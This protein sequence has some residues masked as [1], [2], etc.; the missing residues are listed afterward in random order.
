MGNCTSTK[1]NS[2]PVSYSH[3]LPH[4]P[5]YEETQTCQV[6]I[7]PDIKDNN[8]YVRNGNYD[9]LIKCV[10]LGPPKT[11]K[12]LL[13]S[14]LQDGDID[15]CSNKYRTTIGADFSIV[16]AKYKS[17]NV[18]LQ[19]W[20]SMGDKRFQSITV[21]YLRGAKIVFLFCDLNHPKDMIKWLN[22][23]HK[24]VE[25]GAKIFLI[26]NEQLTVDKNSNSD[27]NIRQLQYDIMN[28]Y[29]TLTI[30]DSFIFDY[31]KQ[32][33]LCNV[34]GKVFQHDIGVPF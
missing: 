16:I 18:K 13:L 27:S 32:Q 2:V 24:H 29:Q 7:K 28:Q 11:G 17:R 4:A 25:F 26:C 6:V 1:T 12:T 21:S 22:G 30:D 33:E 9:A 31:C 19:C 8:Y 5:H 14:T 20:D 3:P 15:V 10:F 34:L 23:V